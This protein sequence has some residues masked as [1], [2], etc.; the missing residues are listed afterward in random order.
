[1]LLALQTQ[2]LEVSQSFLIK[3]T[4]VIG[5]MHHQVLLTA[6]NQIGENVILRGSIRETSSST[7]HG[8]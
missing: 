7:S 8:G 5:E 4:F 2:D 1:M 6:L 3:E